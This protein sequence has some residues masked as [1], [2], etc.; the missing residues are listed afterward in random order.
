MSGGGG[1]GKITVNVTNNAGA[2]IE[3][4]TSD[5]GRTIDIIVEKAA[6]RVASQIARGGNSTASAI[7]RSYGLTRRGR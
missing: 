5:D 1:G 6:E 7:E 4:R 2:A 3:T